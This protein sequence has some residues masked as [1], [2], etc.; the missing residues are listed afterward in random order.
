MPGKSQPAPPLRGEATSDDYLDTLVAIRR[1]MLRFAELQLRDRSMA[2]DVVQE[3]LEA[4]LRGRAGFAGKSSLKTWVFVILRNRIVDQLRRR[5]RTVPFSSLL[6][7]DEDGEQPMETLFD[8]QGAW[9][10]ERRPGPWRD[11]DESME[12]QEF[13]VVFEICLNHLPKHSATA[14]MMREFLGFDSAEICGHLGITA[15]NLNV[16]LHR[17]R[18]RLRACLQAQWFLPG[19]APC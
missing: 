12:Q 16:I 2:E 8:P 11:P 17:A 4:A 6:E 15:G 9:R 10:L 3:A 7:D 1:Q 13:W 19:E 14:F 5:E 18:L